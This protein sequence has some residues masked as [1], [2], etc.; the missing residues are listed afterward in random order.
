MSIWKQFTLS[1]YNL[2]ILAAFRVFKINKAISYTFLLGFIVLAIV[3]FIRAVTNSSSQALFQEA[4]AI[5]I[6][7]AIVSMV[8]IPYIFLMITAGLFIYISLLAGIGVMVARIFK[9]KLIYKQLWVMAAFAITAPTI[10]LTCL[11]GI[12]NQTSLTGWFYF[13]ASICYL[14]GAIKNVPP[15]HHKTTQKKKVLT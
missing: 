14:T 12:L 10:V 3:L 11:D 8:S 7:P 4:E 1:L 9:K 6:S 5:N 15:F 13:I 2:K